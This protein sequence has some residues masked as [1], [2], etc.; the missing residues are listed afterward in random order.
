MNSESGTK[1][2][3]DRM[4]GSLCKYLR[5][6]GYDC[7]SA[8]DMPPGNSREDTIILNIAK[9]EHRYILTQDSE[10][11]RRGEGIAIRLISSDL[12]DQISQLVSA[13]LISPQ[14]RLTRCSRCNALLMK[15]PGIN[16][17]N[18][19]APDDETLMHCPVCYRQYWEGT[20]TRN[21]RVRLEE[22]TGNCEKG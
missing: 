12:G 22:M 21:M 20:H 19:F 5:F 9:T 15:G 1:F 13:G 4:A 6:M 14:I 3:C 18:P 16:P 10:L 17:V 8:N 2:F 11:A 7:I